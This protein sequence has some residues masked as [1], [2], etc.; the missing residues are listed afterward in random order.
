MHYKKYFPTG[1]ID[2]SDL[3]EDRT[4]TIKS[5]AMEALQIPGR[6]KEEKLVIRFEKAEKA[7]VCNKTNATRIARMYGNDTEQWL[8]KAITL[9]FDPNVRFGPDRVGG[10]RVRPKQ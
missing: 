1:F 7:L 9:Y 8:G 3:P 6:A 5:V 10:V 2:E 4:A